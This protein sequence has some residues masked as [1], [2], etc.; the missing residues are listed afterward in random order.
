MTSITDI[1]VLVAFFASFRIDTSGAFV[2]GQPWASSKPQRI[3]E[4]LTIFA[5]S[6][7][8]AEGSRRRPPRNGS[9][10]T[11]S[12]SSP[13][14]RRR[15]VRRERKEEV[16]HDGKLLASQQKPNMGA[17]RFDLE[18]ELTSSTSALRCMTPGLQYGE[19]IGSE[20][21]SSQPVFEYMSLDDLVDPRL[22]FSKKFNNDREFRDNLR[23]AI[24]QDIF[25]TTPFY[26]NLSEKAASILLLPD[27]S[28][29]GSWRIS[30]GQDGDI[31]MKRTTQVLHDA[32]QTVAADDDDIQ[33][34]T[35]DDLFRAIGRLCGETTASTHFIDIFGVQDRSINHSWH[36][37]AGCSPGNCRT[38]L[39]GFPPEDN[40]NGC[41]VFSHIVPLSK[42]CL[43]PE[44]HNRMEPV[45]FDGT[46]PDEYIVRPIYGE[47]KELLLYRDIDVLHSAPDVAYRT[48]IMRFM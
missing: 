13:D 16:P 42:E 46:V 33:I 14:E 19:S 7:P 12:T 21:S 17:P 41:G 27:S 25:D 37:D 43:A 4:V 38:V 32:F 23:S 5:A 2:I 36:L 18:N 6:G 20:E 35:G 44:D 8:K 47:G 10:R 1:F 26:S 30:T 28:L 40:Y 15:R 45:L 39:W 31:R 11:V 34:P 29:E 24:R 9:S 22:G 3:K 48:S